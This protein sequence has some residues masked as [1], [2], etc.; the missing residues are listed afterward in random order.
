MIIAIQLLLSKNDENV[1]ISQGYSNLKE[2]SNPKTKCINAYRKIIKR[3]KE[4]QIMNKTMSNKLNKTGKTKS[5]LDYLF[6]CIR[7]YGGK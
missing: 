3:I 4:L 7:V 6:E 2:T 1:C 5:V